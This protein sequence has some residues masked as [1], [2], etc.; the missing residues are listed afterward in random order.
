MHRFVLESRG[1]TSVLI[2]SCCHRPFLSI[3]NGE[4]RI[5]EKHGNDRHSNSLTIEHL[6]MLLALMTQQTTKPERW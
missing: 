3:E 5:T 4:I 6:R 2:C 1:S